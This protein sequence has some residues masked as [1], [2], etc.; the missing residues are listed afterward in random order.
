MGDRRRRSLDVTWE[1]VADDHQNGRILGHI[2]RVEPILDDVHNDGED[3]AA[4]L[5][6]RRRYSREVRVE[7]AD[8]RSAHVDALRPATRYRVAVSA[9]TLIG[10]G[11]PTDASRNTDADAT[12]SVWVETGEVGFSLSCLRRPT[13]GAA[14][15]FE[16]IR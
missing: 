14:F 7:G 11:P 1:S 5:K 16:K 9:Y 13:I 15:A 3:E 4:T 2:V 10:E 8:V 12:N 6:K